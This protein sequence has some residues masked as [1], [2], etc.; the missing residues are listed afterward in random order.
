MRS[1]TVASSV[2][3]S[4]TAIYVRS[5]IV[6]RD[7]RM[8]QRV[9]IACKVA[10]AYGKNVDKFGSIAAAEQWRQGQASPLSRGYLS[11]L[12]VSFM[13]TNSAR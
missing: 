7:D 5:T 6:V 4:D 2:K 9:S 3:V 1:L 10:R 13:S 8:R 11:R 12:D